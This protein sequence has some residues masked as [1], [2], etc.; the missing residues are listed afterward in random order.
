MANGIIYTPEIEQFIADNQKGISRQQLADLLKAKFGGNFTANGVKSYC[1]RKRLASGCV[2]RY[3]KGQPPASKGIVGF[4][5]NRQGF[6]P[7]SGSFP[8]DHRPY[9]EQPIGY[10]YV[11]SRTG[12]IVVKI[13]KRQYKHKHRLVWE[14]HNGEIP[15][16]HC[17]KFLDNN[18]QNCNI[19]NLICIP[20]GVMRAIGGQLT[21]NIELNKAIIL[22]EI[23][24]HAAKQNARK[25]YRNLPCS[26]STSDRS[27]GT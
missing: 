20:N 15:K 12:Y 14:Q 1:Y 13:G 27:I 4:F 25:R 9:N 16:A 18:R 6:T 19:D 10:E 5:K 11:E 17:I 22:T 24:K 23:L 21:D 2:T 3:V 7:S 26:A 8:K